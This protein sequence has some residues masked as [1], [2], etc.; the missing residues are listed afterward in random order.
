M[1]EQLYYEDVNEGEEITPLVKQPTTTQLVRWAG[2]SGDYNPI[3]FDK[4]FAQSQGLD[5]VIVHGRLK[6]A[7]I[8][9]LLT[10]WVGTEGNLKKLTCRYRG[11]DVP[12]QD[13]TVRGKVTKKYIKDGEHCVELEVW[14]ENPNGEKTTPG[15]ALVVLPS[16][17]QIS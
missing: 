11:M 6:A 17:S 5:G 14:T 2:A 9:Q 4:D 15:T 13:I 7:F 16:R 8:G 12:D 10:D 1:A 3:H